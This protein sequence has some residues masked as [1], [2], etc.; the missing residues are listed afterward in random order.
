[1]HDASQGNTCA[2]TATNCYAHVRHGGSAR[3]HPGSMFF[4]CLSGYVLQL[5]ASAANLNLTAFGVDV[6]MCSV[7]AGSSINGAYLQASSQFPGKGP[8]YPV[9]AATVPYFNRWACGRQGI[10]GPAGTA[11]WQ[12][13]RWLL[14]RLLIR[15]AGSLR[16]RHTM[17]ATT[18]PSS[19]GV[20]RKH[21]CSCQSACNHWLKGPFSSI[22]AAVLLQVLPQV[23]CRVHQQPL[24]HGQHHL[25]RAELGGICGSVSVDLWWAPVQ[26]LCG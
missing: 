7:P 25:W 6:N 9:W 11:S 17:P 19:S 5:A 26:Q 3:H 23:P 4:Y 13:N 1:M 24:L 18:R 12:Y 8:C 2:V 21:A 14:S 16:I 22:V 10:A 15:A 20:Q